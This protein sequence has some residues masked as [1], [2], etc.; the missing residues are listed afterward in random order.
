MSLPHAF[1]AHVLLWYREGSPL[2]LSLSPENGVGH[3]VGLLLGAL[4]EVLPWRVL[5]R[6]A[7]ACTNMSVCCFWQAPGAWLLHT[8]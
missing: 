1:H 7:L 3:L 8:A 6:L 2:S 4:D 5:L